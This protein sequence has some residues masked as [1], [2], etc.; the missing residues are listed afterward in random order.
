MKRNQGIIWKEACRDLHSYTIL[1]MIFISIIFIDIRINTSYEFLSGIYNISTGI[2]LISIFSSLFSYMNIDILLSLPK[3]LYD[4]CIAK[5]IY[6]FLKTTIISSINLIV[7][8]LLNI[9]FIKNNSLESTYIFI[10]SL[11]SVFGISFFIQ[12]ISLLFK[13]NLKFLIIVITSSIIYI[14]KSL[15]FNIN[16]KFVGG[17]LIILIIVSLQYISIIIL[18]NINKEKFI[19]RSM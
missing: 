3:S 17:F 5:T 11:I 13:K 8:I 16:S 7:M 15:I 12:T 6:I 9:A 2:L 1:C 19:K 14:L 4:F 18:K 10:L